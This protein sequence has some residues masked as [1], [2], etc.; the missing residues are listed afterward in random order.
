VTYAPPAHDW[1]TRP[2]AA[3][4]LR[5]EALAAAIAWHQAHESAWPRDFVTASGRY[6]GVADEPADSQVL[7]AV[8][9]RGGPNG[10]I[11]RGG[12]VV[13]EWGDTARVDMS[14]SIAKSYLAVLAGVAV[15]R[16]LIR[17]STS[18]SR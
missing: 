13:A 3:L 10:L 4:G 14:F 2:P 18:P 8:R 9:A 17:T 16:R 11:V 7:G 6:I 5:E 12:Y 1:E 15:T